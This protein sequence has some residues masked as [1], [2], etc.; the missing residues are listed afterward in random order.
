MRPRGTLSNRATRLAA[1]TVAFA[2]MLGAFV[3]IEPAAAMSGDVAVTARVNESLATRARK[4][5]SKKSPCL[6]GY[7][8]MV[9]S[10]SLEMHGRCRVKPRSMVLRNQTGGG[11]MKRLV[12]KN[13]GTRTATGYGHYKSCEGLETCQKLPIK[14]KL[15]GRKRIECKA[16]DGTDYARPVFAGWQYMKVRANFGYGFWVTS[17][18]EWNPDLLDN[19]LLCR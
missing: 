3:A 13:W 4:P 7:S 9:R 10:D 16:W 8:N 5:G 6:A 1:P 14:I 15:S 2:V 11:T 19:D 12:W 18:F 17:D